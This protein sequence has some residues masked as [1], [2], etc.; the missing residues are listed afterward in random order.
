[1]CKKVVI[2]KTKFIVKGGGQQ[3]RFCPNFGK[4]KYIMNLS[5]DDKSC[6]VDQNVPLYGKN[7]RVRFEEEEGEKIAGAEEQC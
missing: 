4:G 3:N 6:E 2:S 1:M 7:D 5:L